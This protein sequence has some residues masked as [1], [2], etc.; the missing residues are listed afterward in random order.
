M[1]LIKHVVLALAVGFGTSAVQASEADLFRSPTQGVEL[2]K[3][4]GWHYLTIDDLVEGRKNIELKI[5]ADEESSSGEAATTVVSIAKYQEPYDDVNPGVSVS[6]TPTGML[7]GAHPRDIINLGL[8]AYP[9]LFDDFKVVEPVQETEFHGHPAYTVSYVVTMRLKDG[10]ALPL[11]A[12]EWF[13]PRA[14]YALN[15]TASARQDE[16]NGTMKEVMAVLETL[17][18][19]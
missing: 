19:D 2:V 10:T 13:V 9:L 1:K 6:I 12:T 18:I 15:V 14:G 17:K 8:A 7:E 11:Q 4:E 3:P 5:K 16:A